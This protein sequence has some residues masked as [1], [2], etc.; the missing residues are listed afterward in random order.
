M[1]W[2]YFNTIM[3]GLIQDNMVGQDF[4]VDDLCVI[5]LNKHSPIGFAD[6]FYNQVITGHANYHQHGV[7]IIRQ[8][9]PAKKQNRRYLWV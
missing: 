2:N 8:R 9:N 7:I 1:F 3:N 6:F 4:S 5:Y